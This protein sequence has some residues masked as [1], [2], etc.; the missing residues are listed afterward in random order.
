MKRLCIA[1]ITG[2]FGSL[3]AGA[4][5]YVAPDGKDINPGTVEAPKATLNAAIRQVRELRRLKQE[6]ESRI[7]LKSGTYY[8]REP[9]RVR[10]EDSGTPTSPLVITSAPGAAPVISGGIL[11]KDWKQNR[12]VVKGLPEAARGRV[13]VAHVPAVAGLLAPRQ[14]WVN[15]RKATRAKSAPGNTMQRIWNWDKTTATAV[16]PLHPFEHL[17]VTEGLEFLI[18]QWWEVANLRVRKLEKGG[19][20]CRVYF[21]EPESRIQNE[22]P[23]PAPWLSPET[24]NSA[25]YLVNSI[26]FLDEPGEWYYDAPARNLYYYPRV[27]ENMKVAKT[28]IPF[29]EQL[30]V[31]SGTSEHPVENV[32][33]SDIRFQ[34]SAWNRPFLQG[35]VPHQAGLYMTEAYKLK[36]A[37]TPEKPSL[38]NQ[39]WVGRPEAAVTVSYASHIRFEGNRFE[40]LA[41]TG[42]DF[43]VGVKSSSVTGSLFKDIGGTAIQGGY[44]G[45]DGTEIHRPYNPADPRVICENIA[46]KNNLVTDAG[47]EDWGA[48]GIGMGFSRSITIE[49]NEMENLP[50]SGI[51]MGWGW[52]PAKNIM[53][54][55]SIRYNKIHHYGRTNYDC[56]GIYTLSA[57]PGTL[58]EENYIDSIYKAPYAHLPTHWF[59]LYADEGSSGI[60]VRNNWTPA[61]KYLQNNNGPGNRWEN[62]G[63]QVAATVK[64]NAGP[65]KQYRALLNEKTSGAVHQAINRQRKELIELVSKAGDLV[66]LRK[67]KILLHEK[68]V[69]QE[70]IGQWK[71]HTVVYGLITD[72]NLLRSQLQNAYPDATIRVYHDMVYEFDRAARCPGAAIAKDWTD[73]MMT[74]NLVKDP[75]KQRE[76][77]DYHAT[78]FEKWPEVSNGFC[79]ADFQQLRVF[80]NGRQLMLVISI[81][82]GKTLKELNPLTT[83]NNQRVNE[84]NK[85]MSGYQEGIEG[86]EKG[87]TWVVLE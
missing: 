1:L 38:D 51:S 61:Q 69:Q 31:L 85:I 54:Q 39:A 6:P 14:L 65:E 8:L 80:K 17:E 62:N 70:T 34:H 9:V 30:F 16:I 56:A 48:V 64:N 12:T 35:H 52:T 20:S 55:N 60:A 32:I 2:I 53:A 29:L 78:Q 7:L 75:Q 43:T 63:P 72:V 11:I 74:A 76:Y 67:L 82:K 47:N 45:D 58:I 10:S 66:D 79:K 26:A 86:T 50:Y 27:Q 21:Y 13:W 37:G 68:G 3:T 19:D 84:W 42:L 87:E 33:I 22:H 28:V 24:G 46:I 18:H 83:K 15:D 73:I 71:G 23:W 49:H 59:Y 5:V 81:P 57:Q 36:P 44:F 25:F 40:H 41:A 4:Q 77:L